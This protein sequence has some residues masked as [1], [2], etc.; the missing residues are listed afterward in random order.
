MS[1]LGGDDMALTEEPRVRP[2]R[3]QSPTPREAVGHG[4]LFCVPAVDAYLD[5]VSV[6]CTHTRRTTHTT[7]QRRVLKYLLIFLLNTFA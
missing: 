4:L 1:D 5:V 2:E 3:R 7:P 6:D